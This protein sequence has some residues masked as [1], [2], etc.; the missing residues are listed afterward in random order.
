[1]NALLLGLDALRHHLE[2]ARARER[3]RGGDDRLVVAVGRGVLDHG[4]VDLERVQGVLVEVGQAALAGA[5]VVEGDAQAEPPQLGEP[6]DGQLG[7]AHELDLRDLELEALG[8]EARLVEDPPHQPDE[9]GVREL[10]RGHVDG[11]HEAVVA[12]VVP[13]LSLQA[14]GAQRPLPERHREPA[15]VGE[16]DEVGRALHPVVAAP[17]QQRLQPHD[18]AGLALDDG[19]PVQLQLPLDEG[20]PQRRLLRLPLGG[21]GARARGVHVP[22][23]AAAL[24]GPAHRHRRALERATRCPARRPGRG[25]C[26]GWR[27]RGG[28]GRRC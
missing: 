25:R 26:R 18:G 14:G 15:H 8:G 3:H 27:S 6:L 13:L 28:R 20:A 4:A 12:R 10:A 24:L 23:V 16:G 22:R 9:G 11:H 19:L 2:P 17:P 5:E 1:M 7:A 21:E